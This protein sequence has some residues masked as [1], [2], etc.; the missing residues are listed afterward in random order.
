MTTYKKA[1]KIQKVRMKSII[2]KVNKNNID[3][4]NRDDSNS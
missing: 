1:V 4:T 2:V 3:T